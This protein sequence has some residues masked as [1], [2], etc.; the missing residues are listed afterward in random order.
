PAG[1]ARV[2]DPVPDRER[3]AEVALPADQPVRV[4]A[5]DP[6][7]VP[8]PH[9]VRVPGQLAAGGQQPRAQLG[10]ARAVADVPLAAGHD[11]QGPVTLLEELA[12]VGAWPWLADQRARFPQLLHHHAPCLLRGLASERG[13][14]VGARSR[15][16]ARSLRLEATISLDHRT[17][18]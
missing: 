14:R 7:L 12:L 6:V 2:A 8:D 9:E 18:R 16:P 4:Q 11:L 10:I 13:I 17:Q 15:Q 5:L 3:N 1:L